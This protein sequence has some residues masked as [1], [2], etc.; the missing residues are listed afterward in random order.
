[1][2]NLFK[3]K[4][5]TALT[6]SKPTLET[7]N[8]EHDNTTNFKFGLDVIPQ[9][10]RHHKMWVKHWSKSSGDYVKAGETLC[11][12]E[13]EKLWT[14]PIILYATVSGYLEIHKQSPTENNLN[15]LQDKEKIFSIHREI[16]DQKAQ[17]LKDKRFE[18]VPFILTDQFT[19][20]KEIKWEVVAGRRP[21]KWYD[22]GTFDS[23]MFLAGNINND[24]L[25]FTINCTDN[26]DYAVFKYPTK[27]YKLTIGSAISFLFSNGEI[28]K[29]E[30]SSKPYKYSEHYA[31]GHIFETKVQLTT[32]ELETLKNQVFT[33]WQIEFAKSDKKVSG[34][35]DSDA[36][37]A[38]RKLV[39]EYFDLVQNQIDNY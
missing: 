14:K 1:M 39:K 37:Y 31:W 23:F 19:G 36:Q 38:V 28:I 13:I 26:K 25:F 4:M 15:Y 22:R 21:D 34:Q 18:N 2:F 7:A 6:P 11:E 17:E 20:I 35:L 33:Q 10:Y 29:L 16:D 27:D 3:K 30:I 32:S 24:T 5:Q 9:E 8:E 12:F